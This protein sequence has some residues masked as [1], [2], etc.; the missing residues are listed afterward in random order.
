MTDADGRFPD[1]APFLLRLP[2][3]ED[4]VAP[5]FGAIDEF[6]RRWRGRRLDRASIAHIDAAG[7]EQRRL[8]FIRSVAAVRVIREAT[9]GRQQ[10]AG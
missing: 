9:S 5:C 4:S 10:G 8:D 1:G 7:V 3:V 2:N 6:V